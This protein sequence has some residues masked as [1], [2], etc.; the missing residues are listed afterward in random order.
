MIEREQKS[1]YLN[2]EDR[3]LPLILRESLEVKAMKRGLGRMKQFDRAL[4]GVSRAFSSIHIAGTNGKGS[5]AT[6]I[7]SCLQIEGK[8]VGL[9]TSPHLVSYHER[10]SINGRSIPKKTAK[11]LLEKIIKTIEIQPTYFELLTLL[12]LC[13]FAEKKVDVAVLEVGMGGRLDTTNIVTPLISVVTS[14]ARDHVQ[15]LGTTLEA[16]AFEK[17]GIIKPKIPVVLGPE[18][19]PLFVFEKIAKE[20]ES[21]LFQ[22][23]GPFVHFEEE[24]RAIAFEVLSHLPYPLKKKAALQGLK[25]VPSCRFEI[26]QNKN[27][28][29]ILDVAHN[30][31][32]L[33]RL[34]ERLA[35]TFKGKLVC[36]LASFSEGKEIESSLEVLTSLAA[37]VHITKD[38]HPRAFEIEKFAA[39]TLFPVDPD[40][41]RAFKTAYEKALHQ[42]QILLVTGTFFIMEEIRIC[43]YQSQIET[44]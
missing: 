19:Q 14:I 25:A 24:N 28:M 21:P 16:I 12:A 30:R 37:E 13:Y 44:S 42:E 10:I 1:T 5:V 7:A 33:K 35:S 3:F 34:F 43:L 31:A 41:P 9:F 29:V 20:N 26:V 36:V 2:C 23:K 15:Y 22:V 40:L 17:G 27:P 39:S 18:V 11:E 6:K 8:K 38:Y 4:K 32:A